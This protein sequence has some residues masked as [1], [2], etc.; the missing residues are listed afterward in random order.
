ML[1]LV[2]EVRIGYKR[3][4]LYSERLNVDFVGIYASYL[5]VVEHK[6]SIWV[7][8]SVLIYYYG[9]CLNS[10]AVLVNTVADI[11]SVLIVEKSEKHGLSEINVDFLKLGSL[12]STVFV[13]L[14]LPFLK[15][16]NFRDS[17]GAGKNEYANTSELYSVSFAERSYF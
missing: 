13:Y 15:S 9:F 8:V 7:K 11:I 1:R 5:F 3:T 6:G 16:G 10:S 2:C 4:A 14:F 17:S 12:K